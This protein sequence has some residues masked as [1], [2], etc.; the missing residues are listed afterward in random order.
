MEEKTLLPQLSQEEITLVRLL[1]QAE[2]ERAAFRKAV[3]EK[4]LLALIWVGVVT[5]GGKILDLVITH[6]K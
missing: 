6:H 1:I 3:M 5:L 4:T 2:K